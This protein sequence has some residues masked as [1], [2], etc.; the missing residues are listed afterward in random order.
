MARIVREI[1]NRELVATR[2]GE[3]P[4]L[5]RDMI[6][7]LG[8]TALPVLDDDRRPIA[9]VSLRDLVDAKRGGSPYSTPAI[10]VRETASI[11]DAA[12]RLADAD[13]HHLVAVDNEG[14]AVGVVS[15]ID[16]V[17][18]LIGLP[19]RHPASFPH[20]DPALG[21]EWCD[22]TPLERGRELVAPAGPGLLVL[23]RGSAGQ[24]EVPVWAESCVNV[25]ARVEELVVGKSR[26]PALA[27]ILHGDT[28]R[29]RSASVANPNERLR[30][31]ELLRRAIVGV[32]RASIAPTA[33]VAG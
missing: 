20:Y 18:G 24:P 3:Q 29:F 13:V 33:F 32:A 10:V 16:V 25:R 4:E 23:V 12:R 2:V 14:R 22:D 11:D 5:L 30:I 9:V 19:A 21:V 31:T 28:L 7:A 17:R 1:M 6:L 8:I 27:A 26:E 15:A